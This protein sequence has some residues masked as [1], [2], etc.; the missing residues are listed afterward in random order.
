MIQECRIAIGIFYERMEPFKDKML[1]LLIQ[2]P[3]YYQLEEGLEYFNCYNFFFEG[4]FRY[5]VE[6]RHPS[7][8]NDLAYN[9]FKT[10]QWSGVRWID[11]RLLQ[12]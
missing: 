2:L 7:W 11:Y 1:A 3:P 8:F 9:F 4:S 5:A 12:W 6:V 10:F